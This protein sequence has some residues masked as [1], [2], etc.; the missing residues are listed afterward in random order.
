[1]I[2]SLWNPLLLHIDEGT[3]ALHSL[4]DVESWETE[5]SMRGIHALEVFVN[6]EHDSP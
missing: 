2:R 6:S 1:M 3:R 4:V 5:L